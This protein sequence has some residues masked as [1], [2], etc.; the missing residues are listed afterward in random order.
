MKKLLNTLFVTSPDAYL[1][2]DGENIV[3]SVEGKERFRIPAHNIEGIVYFGYLGTSPAL[4]GMCAEKNIALSFVTE[5]GKFLGRISGKTN[6]NVLLRRTQYRLADDLETCSAIAK[7]MLTGKI[8]NCRN[9][10]QR[11]LRDHS[12]KIN[13][14]ALE[15]AADKLTV[16]LKSLQ[17]MVGL[18][19]IRGCEGEAAGVYFS[20]FDHLIL[21]QKDKFYFT[22]R[23]R[24]PPKDNVNALLS[25]YYMLLA[26]D[27]QSALE[28][29]GLDSYV[30]FLHRDR[31]G[32]PSL[33]LDLMEELRPYLADRLTLSLINRKQISA[34]GFKQT[35]AGA[36]L[37][38]DDTRKEILTAWQKRKQET[39]VHPYL[40]EEIPVGLLPYTQALL[41]SRYLRGDLDNYPVF[42]MK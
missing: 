1:A 38:R 16:K 24:R 42:I 6:G 8:A 4:I 13:I 34:S 9:I 14:P 7:T 23:N 22:D 11:S 37:I 29:V 21:H 10:I 35:D 31:P 30:G 17:R 15:E 5:Y 36:V 18:D 19:A 2:K 12:Q 3:V 25:F 33:A 40:N 26:H 28:S 32:R 20:V 39:I 27:V 41:L